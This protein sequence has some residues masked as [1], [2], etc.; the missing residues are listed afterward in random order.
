MDAVTARRLF[1][2]LDRPQADE[3][4]RAVIAAGNDPTAAR[5]LWQLLL[6]TSAQD[7]RFRTILQR[8]MESVLIDY[9]TNDLFNNDEF[10]LVLG[11]RISLMLEAVARSEG[12]KQPKAA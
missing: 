11:R 9:I 5:N 1:Q 2:T 10:A 7:E 4:V 8:V 12:E 6:T 3:A